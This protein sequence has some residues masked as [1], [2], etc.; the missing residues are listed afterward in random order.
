M[1]KGVKRAVLGVAA[2]AVVVGG[3][4][5]C[6]GPHCPWG[7]PK[8]GPWDYG[9]DGWAEGRARMVERISDRLG[10]NAEQKVKLDALADAM[11]EQRMTL[12]GDN[13]LAADLGAVI[14]GRTFDRAKAQSLV[15]QKVAAVQAHSPTV[16]DRM[17]AFYDSLT[18]PQQQKVRDRL[19][20]NHGDRAW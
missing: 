14:A 20:W 6:G 5:A 8:R 3:M 7:S 11:S 13:G 12:R 9:E 15:E 10:L 2:V 4:A 19:G 16:L 17:A 1:R 18:P